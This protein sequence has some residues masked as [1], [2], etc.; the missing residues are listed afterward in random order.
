MSVFH[1]YDRRVVELL[2]GRP[3]KGLAI[4][5]SGKRPERFAGLRIVDQLLISLDKSC[6]QSPTHPRA[7]NW[8][9]RSCTA[10]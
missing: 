7:S 5:L 9:W 8:Q 1:E 6:W 4:K 3:T 2:G 10:F